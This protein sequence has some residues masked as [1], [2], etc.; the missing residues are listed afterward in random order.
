MRFIDETDRKLSVSNGSASVL[1]NSKMKT[2][3]LPVRFC[4]WD[5]QLQG[6]VAHLH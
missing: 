6:M 4:C 5:Y 2:I 3:F 1:S